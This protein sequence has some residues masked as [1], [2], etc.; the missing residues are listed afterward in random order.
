MNADSSQQDYVFLDGQFVLDSDATIS[1]KT[2]ALHYGTACFEGIRSYYN[3]DDNT[4][5]IFRLKEHY[6]RFLNSCKILHITLP[7]TA[8]DLCQITQDL[9]QRNFIDKDIYI[10]PLAYK[11][12]PAVGNFNLSTLS[13]SITI[14]TMPFPSS[15]YAGG[16]KA[17][18][19]SWTRVTD[20]SIPPRGKISGAYV[21]SC[22]AKTD[23]ILSGFDE[24]LFLDKNGHVIEGTVE[25]LFVIRNNTIITPPVYDDILEGITR[26]TIIELCAKELGKTVVERSINRSE[27]Y[28]AEEVF[29]VGTGNEIAPLIEIDHRKVNEGTIGPL[30]EKIADLYKKIVR[31]QLPEYE[32]FVT[33]VI[34]K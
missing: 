26:S 31:G 17:N 1:V 29:L 15:V 8:D 2:H 27:L 19:S 22:L 9:I 7:F 30:T 18:V 5:N 28:Q 25:N 10:R 12:S 20:N 13:N 14:Y 24:G 3:V 16:I 11:S 23:S 33:K 34:K 21:N 6:T 32:T 4:H